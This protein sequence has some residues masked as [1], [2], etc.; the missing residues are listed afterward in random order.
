M[1]RA[2]NTPA[3]RGRLRVALLVSLQRP[4][5]SSRELLFNST[6]PESICGAGGRSERLP[7]Y[8]RVS[9]MEPLSTNGG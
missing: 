5:P 4:M 7:G 6:A 8:W 1:S 9:M 3:H 2:T